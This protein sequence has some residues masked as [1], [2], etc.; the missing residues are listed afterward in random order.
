MDIVEQTV[1]NG[2][3][4]VGIILV[5]ALERSQ[6][7]FC[8]AKISIS[9]ALAN[10]PGRQLHISMQSKFYFRNNINHQIPILFLAD[11]EI[12]WMLLKRP[13]IFSIQCKAPLP[14]LEK[15]V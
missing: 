13:D 12:H 14:K 8:F 7:A 2:L 10:L 6:S 4:A 9:G 5:F 11:A 15:A 1:I 3:M